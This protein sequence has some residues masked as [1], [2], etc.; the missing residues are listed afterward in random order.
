MFYVHPE[1]LGKIRFLFLDEHIFRRG[2]VQPPTSGKKSPTASPRVRFLGRT[3]VTGLVTYS[4]VESSLSTFQL[5]MLVLVRFWFYRC[6]EGQNVAFALCG[7]CFEAFFWKMFFGPWRF[8]YCFFEWLTESPYA[9][10]DE[11]GWC[12]N[13]SN[14]STCCSFEHWQAISWFYVFLLLS[15]Q[16]YDSPCLVTFRGEVTI[17][18]KCTLSDVDKFL[19]VSTVIEHLVRCCCCRCCRCCCCCCCWWWWWS[20]RYIYVL[21]NQY[22]CFCCI[23][24]L[25]HE[26]SKDFTAP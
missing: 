16:L 10:I 23:L 4:A 24:A 17:S 2:L 11:V 9:T 26:W 15:Y 20:S 14:W 1:P 21:F 18:I 5:Q 8:F 13:M 25:D 6:V 7:G 3:Q 12:L 19:S 22:G